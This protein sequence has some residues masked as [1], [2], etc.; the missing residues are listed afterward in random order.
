MAANSGVLIPFG[1][2][3]L[4]GVLLQV[5]PGTGP[6][7]NPLAQYGLLG[8]ILAI[9][10]W[11]VW[12]VL[13]ND[14]ADLAAG[15]AEVATANAEVRELNVYIRDRVVPLVEGCATALRETSA[16]NAEVVRALT[17]VV[18][19]LDQREQRHG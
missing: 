9:T 4:A 14:R 1:L 5:N 3:H 17:R 15:K 18:V 7:F 10:F 19:I 6:D 16:S 12:F 13:R 2:E 8:A 11:F